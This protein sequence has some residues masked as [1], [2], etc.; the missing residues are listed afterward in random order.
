MHITCEGVGCGSGIF[1]GGGVSC[2]GA[3]HRVIF[4]SDGSSAVSTCFSGDRGRPSRRGGLSKIKEREFRDCVAV[5]G[6]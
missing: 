2:V 3:S 4:D 5:D 6:I 1:V